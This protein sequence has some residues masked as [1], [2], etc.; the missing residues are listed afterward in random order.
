M[1]LLLK[2]YKESGRR[3]TATSIKISLFMEQENDLKF[4]KKKT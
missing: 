3:W 4:S 2:G 1:L